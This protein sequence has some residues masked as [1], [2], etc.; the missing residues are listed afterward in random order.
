LSAIKPLSVEN[1]T[2]DFGPVHALHQ[3]SFAIEPGEVFGYLGPNGAGK[4]TTLRIA[5]G[6]VHA[7]AGT[8]R[9]FGRPPSDHD[10]RLNI[11]FLPGDLRLYGDLKSVQLLDYFARFRPDR[12][13]TLR[14]RLIEQLSLESSVLERRVKFLSHGTRQ[15]LGLI[16]AMQQDP[17]LLLLDEPSNGLDPLVQQAF[18]QLIREAAERGR[19]VLFSSHLLNEVQIVCHRVAILRQGRLVALETVEKL[20][21]RMVRRL[22]VRFT[23]EIPAQLLEQPQVARY[24]ARGNEVVLWIRGEV[25][26]LL[27]AL[28]NTS[29]RDF[30]F[31]EAELEDTFLSYYRGETPADA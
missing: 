9:L 18:R 5:L 17:E 7:S 2:K 27:A 11:G 16:I 12:P 31:P 26:S 25:S 15:K 29:V 6:L 23:G 22:T 21:A 8:V 4:T 13:A 10:S 1:L 20:R 30:V 19:S 24:E 28:A 3:V 14:S